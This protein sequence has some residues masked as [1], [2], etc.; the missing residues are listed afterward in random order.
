MTSKNHSQAF[1]QAYSEESDD[2]VTNLT[3]MEV[4]WLNLLKRISRDDLELIRKQLEKQRKSLLEIQKKSE[5]QN[6]EEK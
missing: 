1:S 5:H 4:K 2:K 3:N 6:I